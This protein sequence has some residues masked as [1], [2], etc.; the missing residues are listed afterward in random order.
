M[1]DRLNKAIQQLGPAEIEQLADAAE[2]MLRAKLTKQASWRFDWV[3]ALEDA[4]FRSA[5]EAQR[6]AND[7]RISLL[8]RGAQK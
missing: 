3:G 8:A 6:F 1:S 5:T 4:G 2:A 7:E